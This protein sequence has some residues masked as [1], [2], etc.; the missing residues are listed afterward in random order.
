MSAQNRHAKA[1]TPIM[2]IFGD[3]AYKE[4]IKLRRVYKVVVLNPI[5]LMSL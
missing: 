3:G 5:G 2:T 1:P 4:V